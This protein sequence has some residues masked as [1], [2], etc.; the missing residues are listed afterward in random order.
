MRT[1]ANYHPAVVAVTMAAWVGF[2]ML[3]VNPILLVSSLLGAISYILCRGD[4]RRAHLALLLLFLLMT[5]VNPLVSHNGATVLFFFNQNPVTL[6]ATLWGATSAG[7]VVTVLLWF[8]VFGRI[9][10]AERLLCLFGLLSP[11][12]ALTLSMSLR[13]VPRFSRQMRRVN[14]SQ[15]AMGLYRDDHI[16]C[17]MRG[18]ARV[19]SVMLTWALENG[20]VTADSMTARGYGIGRRTHF[21]VHR[22][23]RADAYL[24]GFVLLLSVLAGTAACMGRF[25]VVYYPT[26]MMPSVDVWSVVGYVAYGILCLIPTGLEIWEVCRWKF[27]QSK[28]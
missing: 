24:L 8:F 7:I 10:T 23:R 9:M 4:G 11:R 13:Y 22:F 12:L 16:A 18:G 27:L 6:E 19:F 26:F 17:R 25:E 14:R 21:T 3:G 2:L 15:R 1:F 5:L 28:I 20:I